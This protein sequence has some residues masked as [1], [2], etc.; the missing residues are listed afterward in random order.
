MRYAGNGTRPSSFGKCFEEVQAMAAA[1]SFVLPKPVTKTGSTFL[2]RPFSELLAE[3][4][5]DLAELKGELKAASRGHAPM[6][7]DIALVRY[8]YGFGRQRQKHLRCNP[9]G[10][11]AEE[12]QGRDSERR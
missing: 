8:L 4:S 9:C 3:R 6:L 2:N 7:D 10:S 1:D 12:D 5:A 11:A